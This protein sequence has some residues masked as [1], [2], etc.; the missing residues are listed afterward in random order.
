MPIDQTANFKRAEITDGFPMAAEDDDVYFIG[1]DE[2]PDPANGEYNLVI[3]DQTQ[4]ARPDQ[5]PNVEIVRATERLSSVE[6]A[7]DRAQEGTTA[8]DHPAGSAVILAATSKVFDDVAAT[9]QPVENFTS[10][11]T[12]AGD[13][14]TSDG[15]G[16]IGF[17]PVGGIEEVA[18]FGD[19][20]AISP[21][22]LA[23]VEDEV[24]YYASKPK[25]GFD[26][27]RATL[28]DFA[29]VNDGGNRGVD[30]TED[31]TKLYQSAYYSQAV[32]EFTFSTPYDINTLTETNSLV[33][34]QNV[35]GNRISNDG[36]NLYVASND[37]DKIRQFTL[38]TE[39]DLNS[40]SQVAEINTAQTDVRGLDIS[41]DGTVLITSTRDGQST[42]GIISQFNLST[43][44]DL[45]SATFTTAISAKSNDLPQEPLFSARGD[46]LYEADFNGTI[47][48]YDMS[49]AFNIGTA[50]L[51]TT[52]DFPEDRLSGIGFAK[53]G[54]KFYQSHDQFGN[55]T[56]ARIYEFD[57]PLVEGWTPIT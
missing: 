38:S 24:Q 43:A 52:L 17:A 19:L 49:D 33:I 12:T 37:D 9:D 8:A 10:N 44:F 20:P 26:L 54:E 16:G 5:D 34:N 42:G 39:F 27:L 45:S 4:F 18:T 47:F 30:V 28:N 29:T 36:K 31:G 13:V 21:P 56:T 35:Q 25:Q 11:S 41:K 46:K 2:F 1:A 3:F 23:F 53:N 40:A 50:D 14:L 57:V 15:V 22:Q 51:K 55:I 32:K 7:V 6:L 48:Q